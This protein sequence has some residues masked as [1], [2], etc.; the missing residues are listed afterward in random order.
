MAMPLALILIG[1]SIRVSR[2]K[3]DLAPL[4]TASLIKLLL[5]PVTAY[6]LARYAFHFT[7]ENLGLSVILT[8][9]P[10]SVSSYIMAAEMDAD[11]EFM[12]TA[13]GLTTFASVFTISLIKFLLV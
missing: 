8:A 7:G 11:E 5:M 13:I 10:T 4:I 2:I 9:T 3:G 12:A 1:A 6:L